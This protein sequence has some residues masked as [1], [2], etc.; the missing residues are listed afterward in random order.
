MDDIVLCFQHHEPLNHRN[1]L[2]L[3]SKDIRYAWSPA[4]ELRQR[5]PVNT[6]MLFNHQAS[7]LS[8]N[9][10]EH[11][12]YVNFNFHYLLIAVDIL[13]SLFSLK[14]LIS[15]LLLLSYYISLNGILS[16]E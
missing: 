1:E 4:L 3:M 10:R 2:F 7:Q 9:P 14:I 5:Y 8:M 16:S 11:G 12:D 15:P 6:Y 13:F